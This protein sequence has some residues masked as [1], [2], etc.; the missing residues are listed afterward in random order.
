MLWIQDEEKWCLK[1]Q[2]GW[3]NFYTFFDG[4]AYLSQNGLQNHIW[5][6]LGAGFGSILQRLYQWRYER[7]VKLRIPEVYCFCLQIEFVRSVGRSVDL[8]SNF[9]FYF[10]IIIN[11]LELFTECVQR[12]RNVSVA[13]AKFLRKLFYVSN[14]QNESIKS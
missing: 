13:N 1:N 5:I 6:N 8:V 4:K 3:S 10:D 11:S 9:Y 12:S 14:T 7:W 2:K